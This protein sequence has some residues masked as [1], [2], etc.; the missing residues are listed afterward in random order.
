MSFF[1]FCFFFFVGGGGGSRVL[2]LGFRVFWGSRASDLA[3]FFRV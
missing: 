2:G 3:F 1:C